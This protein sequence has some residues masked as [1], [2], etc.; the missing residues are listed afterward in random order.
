[1]KVLFAASEVLPFI[2][3]GGLADVAGSLPKAMNS[4][5]V[6][7][8]VVMPLYSQ[9]SDEYRTNMKY[10]TSFNVPV[11]WRQ[12]YCG[13]FETVLDG[14]VCYFLDNEH[15][16]HRD[17]IYGHYDDAERFA[18]FSR[19]VLEMMKHIKFKPNVIHSNDWHTALIPV[20]YNAF[21]V[22]SKGY[23][24]IKNVFTIHNIEF[25]GKY[26]WD[27][28][29][30]L[31]G[32][33][34]TYK[35]VLKF[36]GIVNFMKGAIATADAVTAVSPSYAE[37]LQY[38]YFSHGL[39]SVVKQ[40]INKFSGILNGLDNVNYDPETDSSIFSNYSAEQPEAKAVNKAKLQELL[41]LALDESSLVVG[42]V[43]R[44][45]KQK[46]L[47]LLEYIFE[48]MMAD[49]L[50]LIVLGK[51]DAHFESFFS[52]MQ[53]K[54][55]GK[56][57]V[58][59]GFNQQLAR[60]IYAGSDLLLM[61]SEMEPCGLAQMIA[62]RYGT[63]PLVRETGGLKDSI[64]DCSNPEGNGYTFKDFNAHDM[65]GA[66][67]RAEGAFVQKDYWKKLVLRAMKCDFSWNKSAAEYISLYKGLITI[68]GGN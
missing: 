26:G 35:Q 25:Q 2:A 54:Y 51:G 20:F 63:I 36:D 41:G 68:S 37:E 16:F 17:G 21:Y 15:Y 38:P 43:G 66:L 55:P 46:G 59:I 5:D 31:L 62:L 1:M 11:A 61:P 7:C 33:P 4:G 29:G 52:G 67:R 10:V 24:S 60:R 34:E 65:L 47:E 48:E 23:K 50:Q 19:A 53:E 45:A 30:D 12:Q 14:V 44:L 28:Y 22:G 39:D 3:T 8:R 49:H 40:Y 42:M 56:L 57:A 18:F 13:L 64:T 58:R 32:L 27:I 6:D 9:I